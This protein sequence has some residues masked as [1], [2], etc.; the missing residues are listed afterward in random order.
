MIYHL[1]KWFEKMG[2][3]IPGANLMN[4]ISF[5]AAACIILALVIAFWIGPKI[6][7][8]LQ[9]KQI[10][11][12]IRDLGL[13]GQLAKKGTP[14]MGGLI[15]LGSILIPVILFCKLDSIY[16][17]LLIFTTV[18]LGAIGFKDDSIKVFK[19]NKEGMKEK[20]KI[21][22]QLAVGLVVG[23]TL[24]ISKQNVIRL[25]S[26]TPQPGQQTEVVQG[27]GDEKV[28]YYRD[29]KSRTTTIPFL[30]HN[31]FKYSWLAP[32]E[33]RFRDWATNIVYVIVVTFIIIAV[34]NGT[35]LTD[36]MD[37]LAAGTSA[38]VGLTVA[39]LAYLSGNAIFAK[40]LNIMYIPNTAEIVIFMAAFV[41]AL[42]GFLWY[43]TYPA[44]VFMGDT[45]SLA[46]G[47]IIA[48]ASVMIRKE[49]LIPIFCGIFFV[50][51]LSVL[52]QR[53]YFKYT[54]VKKGEGVRVFRMSPLHH[55]FQ[56][57]NP[58][59]LIQWPHHVIPEAKITV[60]FWIITIVLGILSVITLK[61]R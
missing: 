57:E 38:I 60:R 43:N 24:L 3:D 23:I 25:Y 50:E 28:I 11:E 47:G 58:D 55:H 22:G 61:I 34:S 56:K 21:F 26:E 35:N 33:G 46:L 27:V 16:V 8:K 17:L 19:K 15:I 41:G 42:I 48:V 7:H 1:F 52:I 12:T 40:Y 10:G 4:Y 37:G 45:G 2:W 14:T 51:S 54:R 29:V 44:Q 32:G 30:K 49:F 6:I 5:R 59:A 20:S 39:I 53:Y 13:E 31:E 9:K 18:C 36:G